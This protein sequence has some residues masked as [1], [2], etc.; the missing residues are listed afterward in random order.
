MSGTKSYTASLSWDAIEFFFL[1]IEI[2]FAFWPHFLHMFFHWE[3]YE[4]DYAYSCI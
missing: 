1:E 4:S 2:G 3:I